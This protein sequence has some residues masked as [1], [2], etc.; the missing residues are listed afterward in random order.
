VPREGD[1]FEPRAD[2]VQAAR[3]DT[4]RVLL[5]EDDVFN[6]LAAGMDGY[7]AKPMD[8]Q[9]LK[10]SMESAMAARAGKQKRA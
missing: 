2:A 5:A 7:V 1:G 3:T 8:S 9:Q 6:L 10:E 4:S